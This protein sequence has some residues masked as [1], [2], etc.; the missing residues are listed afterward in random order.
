MGLFEN[1]TVR[2]NLRNISIANWEI[3][4]YS[5][6]MIFVN[7]FVHFHKYYGD[8]KIIV[9]WNVTPCSLVGAND[10]DESGACV[11]SEENK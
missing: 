7:R 1:F 8:I 5:N 11:F 10:A 6:A 4:L 9:F 3:F 2:Y